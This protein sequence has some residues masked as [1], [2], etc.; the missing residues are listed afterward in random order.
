[1][2]IRAASNYAEFIMRSGTADKHVAQ[3][4]TWLNQKRWEQYNAPQAPEMP[5]PGMI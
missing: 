3:A 4:T 2:I 1:M 5:R